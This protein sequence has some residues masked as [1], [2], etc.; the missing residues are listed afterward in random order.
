VTTVTRTWFNA[1][2]RVVSREDFHT[3][4]GF[5]EPLGAAP[6]SRQAAATQACATDLVS[7]CLLGRFRARVGFTD[8]E[9]QPDVGHPVPVTSLSGAFDLHELPGLDLY[10]KMID[11]RAENGH[12]WFFFGALTNVP[13]TIRV[14]DTV[15]GQEKSYA[16]P[17]GEFTAG[18]DAEAF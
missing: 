15:T 17:P 11:G 8:F 4:F 10:V 3:F 2:G 9:G 12:F 1:P 18:M 5:G 16:H 6:P 13:Y 7:L 14:T